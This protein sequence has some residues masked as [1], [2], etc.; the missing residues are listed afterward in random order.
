MKKINVAKIPW[1]KDTSPGGKYQSS[2]KQIS[3]KLGDSRNAWPKGGHPFN[4]ELTK[5]AP[6][7]KPCPFHSHTT[8]W[9]MFVI[10]SGTGSVRAGRK[11]Y[12]VKAGDAFM[13]PPGEA[14]QITNLGRKDL[15]FYIIA[16]NPPVDIFHYPDA[17]KWGLRPH[18]KYFRMTEADYYDGEE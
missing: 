6:G 11:Q 2:S 16:D 14:H 8:Q 7:K 4:V 1:T 17:G 13:H 18:G 12:T 9:E 15:I 10:V 5:V 3:E